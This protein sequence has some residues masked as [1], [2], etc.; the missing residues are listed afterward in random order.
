MDVPTLKKDQTSQGKRINLSVSPMEENVLK[1]RKLIFAKQQINFVAVPRTKR[2]TD[3]HSHAF[4]RPSRPLSRRGIS[5][6][7]LHHTP[8]KQLQA[9]PSRPLTQKQLA[10]PSKG[11][12]RVAL[13]NRKKNLLP[14]SKIQ[15]TSQKASNFKSTLKQP[16]TLK[17]PHEKIKT[18]LSTNVSR[19]PAD[20]FLK[21]PNDFSSEQ[22]R[23]SQPI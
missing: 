16:F 22:K 23:A 1:E 9:R 8:F 15:V 6:R 20:F 5:T 4:A 17:T 2:L 11:P 18:S 12:L 10:R 19:S 3:M 14:R 7:Q 13:S 21:T